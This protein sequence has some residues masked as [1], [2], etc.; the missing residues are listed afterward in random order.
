MKSPQLMMETKNII[1][2]QWLSVSLYVW[3][4]KEFLKV[5]MKLRKKN[6]PNDLGKC[7]DYTSSFFFCLVY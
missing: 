2:K 1:Q 4:T 6:S 7:V 5:K 3:L